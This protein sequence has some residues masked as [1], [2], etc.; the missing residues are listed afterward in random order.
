[1]CS[2]KSTGFGSSIAA[3]ISPF[4]SS[5]VAGQTHLRPG[6]CANDDSGFCEWNGPPEKPPPDGRRSTIGT[7]VPA[8]QRCFAATVTR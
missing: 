5:G 4:A 3:M 8:R 1:M 6:M 2:K 7:G